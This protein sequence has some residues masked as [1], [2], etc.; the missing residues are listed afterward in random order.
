MNMC[1]IEPVPE[2]QVRFQSND[3]LVACGIQRLNIDLGRY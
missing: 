1:D 3:F 2:I